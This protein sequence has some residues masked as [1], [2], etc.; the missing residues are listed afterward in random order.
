MGN[1]AA[2]AATDY[3][4]AVAARVEMDHEP[5]ISDAELDNAPPDVLIAEIRRLRSALGHADAKAT[6]CAKEASKWHAKYEELVIAADPTREWQDRVD[7]AHHMTAEVLRRT[8]R[9][10]AKLRLVGAEL[11]GVRC[12][13]VGQSLEKA[14]AKAKEPQAIQAVTKGWVD[15][16]EAISGRVGWTNATVAQRTE[17]RASIATVAGSNPAGGSEK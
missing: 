2:A 5:M 16:D 1:R 17:R 3:A 12:R 15:A 11:H 10:E 8:N 14:L 4:L 9:A 7:D 13:F 6:S